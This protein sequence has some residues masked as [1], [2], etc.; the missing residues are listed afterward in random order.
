MTILHTSDAVFTLKQATELAK[1]WSKGQ[2]SYGRDM[3]YLW[4][5]EYNTALVDTTKPGP[6][7][8]YVTNK[9]DPRVVQCQKST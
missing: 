4:S 2:D 7:N 5:K 1:Y 8:W 3:S 6:D 9:F